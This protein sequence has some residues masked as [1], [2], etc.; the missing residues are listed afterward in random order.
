MKVKLKNLFAP[1]ACISSAPLRFLKFVFAFL[2]CF[3][4][5]IN[6][7]SQDT[8]NKKGEDGRKQGYWIINGSMKATPGFNAD[9]KIE[10]GKY[11]DDKKQGKWISYHTTGKIKEHG[12]FL[13]NKKFG[14]WIQYYPTEKI[15]IKI[16]YKNGRPNGSYS[17]YYESG[18]IEEEGNWKNSHNVGGFKRYFDKKDTCGV[19][20][21]EKIFDENGKQQSW[22]EYCTQD[23]A[24]VFYDEKL[25]SWLIA[26]TGKICT[27]KK[28]YN[29]EIRPEINYIKKKDTVII[30]LDTITG[31][32]TKH[33]GNFKLLEEGICKNGNLWDGKKYYY[34]INGRLLKTEKYKEGKI[35][36]EPDPVIKDGYNK[37]YDK[38]KRLILD[39][40]FRGGKLWNGKRYVYDKNGL[41]LKIELYKEGKYVGDGKIDD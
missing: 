14:E 3:L 23:K 34:D 13:D 15:K 25:N 21:M 10:E 36:A 11:V 26:G 37:V 19:I 31:K 32:C 9:Q 33:D 6:L 30:F 1:S 8:I 7:F 27:H 24:L 16:E 41:I 28:T 22:K 17:T 2:T 29:N 18:C 38:D 35:V 5:T 12:I 4:L 20:A 39:G 40:E